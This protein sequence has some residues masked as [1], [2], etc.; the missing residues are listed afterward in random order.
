MVSLGR[1]FMA[2]VHLYLI[3]EPSLGLAPIVSKAVIDALMKIDIEN[4]A[5][6]IAE[7]I[8][9]LLKGRVDRILGMHDGKI[10]AGEVD[11]NIGKPVLV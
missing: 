8:V 5:M 2:D 1:G 11:M 7:Q 4:G 10:K 9:S 6:V 3:D